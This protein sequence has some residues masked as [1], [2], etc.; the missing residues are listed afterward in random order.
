MLF[1]CA[2]GATLLL[3]RARHDA[4]GAELTLELTL[5]A[6]DERTLACASDV[7]PRDQGIEYACAFDRRQRPQPRAPATLQPFVTTAGE[8]VVLAGVFQQPE[9]RKKMDSGREQRGKRWKLRCK[10][11]VLARPPAI[12]ARFVAD[13]GWDER[14]NVTAAAV[15]TCSVLD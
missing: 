14:R 11:K 7:R 4:L 12:S 6:N 13:G 10:A 2:L 1:G 8:V 3:G 15:Q 9:L 5:I